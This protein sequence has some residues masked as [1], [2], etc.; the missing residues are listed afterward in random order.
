M[1]LGPLFAFPPP[2]KKSLL[3]SVTEIY[4]TA[5][6]TILEELKEDRRIERKPIGVRSLNLGDYFSMWA[7]TKPDGGIIVVGQENDG[8][9]SGCIKGGQNQINEVERAGN[10]HCP[11]ARYETKKVDVRLPD[12]TADFVIMLR[13]FYR[14]DKLVRTVRNEAVIRIA[15]SKKKVPS[16]FTWVTQLYC[17]PASP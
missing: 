11:D 14:E 10:V 12:G 8:A 2:V 16:H 4:S 1:T 17:S 3:L 9:M 5:T 7:N 15:D 6:Q 13:I